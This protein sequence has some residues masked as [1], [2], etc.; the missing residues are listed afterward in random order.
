MLTQIAAALSRFVGRPR[1]AKSKRQ[2]ESINRWTNCHAFKVTGMS[3]LGAPFWSLG[4]TQSQIKGAYI[5]NKYSV[6]AL[7]HDSIFHCKHWH[8]KR[9]FYLVGRIS[10][11]FLRTFPLFQS[12][13]KKGFQLSFVPEESEQRTQHITNIFT[14]VHNKYFTSCN[15][16]QNLF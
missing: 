2:Y 15:V 10:L 3:H 7:L 14:W 12:Q 1:L 4:Q 8:S 9:C 6:T 16:F 13:L 5:M 11:L